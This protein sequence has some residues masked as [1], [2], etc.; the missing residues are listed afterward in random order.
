MKTVL[1]VAAEAYPFVTTGGLGDAVGSLPR[2]LREQGVEAGI[3]L[4]EHGRIPAHWREGMELVKAFSVP[5]GWRSQYCGLKR[6]EVNGLSY[7][8]IDN[9]Y[10]FG[11]AELYGYPDDAERFAFFGKA[12]LEAL[13]QLGFKPQ[14][15]HCHD[16]QSAVL[17][18]LLKAHYQD[19]QA[20]A[21]IKTMLTIHNV[22]YQGIFP[23]PVLGDLL[24][25]D[26]GEYFT[27]GKLEFYGQVNFL[28][29][30]IVFADAVTTVGPGYAREILTPEKGHGLD[31]VLRQRLG[32]FWGVLN[33]IDEG[34][35]N[36][37][38]DK[39]IF[40]NYSRS[41]PEQK[42][43]NKLKLQEYLG[44]QVD[45]DIPMVCLVSRAGEASGLHLVTAVLD[46]L[47]AMALQ[48]V[49]MNG[50]GEEHGTVFQVA[51][52][53]YPGKLS[54]NMFYEENLA[55]R[56][57]AASDLYLGPAAEP[58]GTTEMIALRYGCVPVVRQTAWRQETVVDVD[59]AGGGG[60][61]FVFREAGP[62]GLLATLARAL[63]FYRDTAR[64]PQIVATA[65]GSE[66]GWR[67]S[68]AE[69]RRLY[70][71]MAK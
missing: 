20:Y 2:E 49:V 9:E 11:R 4:P 69:Y 6:L 67:R 71:L 36:P 21:G 54:A 5:L 29:A 1:F 18:V 14:V 24:E 65:M 52:H 63:G 38:D 41:S 8:F 22:E 39:A 50:A 17:P 10:Y 33:G 68:A 44:L 32:T 61:G 40:A 47:M 3:I 43:V 16:W 13:P 46:D 23:A 55:R 34:A 35:F 12:V 51:A 56:I 60:N 30:G 42:R 64:W 62:H 53:H 59:E 7:Y 31:G 66:V 28:K 45:P 48:L 26:P 15:V 57:F 19:R 27:S 25:L 37:A 70:E 58:C